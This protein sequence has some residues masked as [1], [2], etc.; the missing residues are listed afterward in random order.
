MSDQPKNTTVHNNTDDKNCHPSTICPS[1]QHTTQS[2]ESPVSNTLTDDAVRVSVRSCC[3]C[4][5]LPWMSYPQRKHKNTTDNATAE[6]LH[7]AARTYN[8]TTRHCHISQ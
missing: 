6:G 7:C 4:G 5:A 3:V 2:S 1:S 8:T